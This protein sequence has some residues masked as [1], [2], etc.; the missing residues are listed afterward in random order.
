MRRKYQGT[1]AERRAAYQRSAK[2]KATRQ[3]YCKSAK[4]KAWMRRYRK[5]PKGYYH[6]EKYRVAHLRAVKKYNARVGRKP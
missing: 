4:F 1:L 5:N 2:G 6:T 3:R